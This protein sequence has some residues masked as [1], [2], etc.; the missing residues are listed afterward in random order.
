MTEKGEKREGKE[1]SVV[2]TNSEINGSLGLCQSPSEKDDI[3]K[4]T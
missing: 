1:K 2:F 4:F 3:L